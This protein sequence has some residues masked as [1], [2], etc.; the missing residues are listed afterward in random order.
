MQRTMGALLTCIVLATGLLAGG[1]QSKQA[2]RSGALSAAGTIE[3]EE[4]HV[5]PETGG[6]LVELAAEKGSTVEAGTILARLDTALL[7]AQRDHARSAVD[8]AQAA[9]QV[10]QAQL[11]KARAGARP[12]E[13]AAARSALAASEAG[14]KAAQAQRD[15][16]QARQSS[17]EA[18]L[19]AAQGQVKITE[20]SQAAAQAGIDAAQASLTRAKV[21]AT[22]E[23]LGIAEHAVEEAR[24]ALWGAQAQ[25]DSICGGVGRATK[26]S[27]CDGAKAAVQRAEEEVRM[28]ELRL[29]ETRKGARSEDLA[30]LQA[31]VNQA[32][33]GLQGA[34]AQGGTAQ[35]GVEA[36]Q[37]SL[38][39]SAADLAGADAGL[40]VAKAQRDQAQAA[41]DLMQAGARR[42]DLASLEAQ[43]R[44]A[45]A[46]LA[47][48]QAALRGIETQLARMT[49]IA[50]VRGVVLER[51]GHVG[52]L[53]AQGTPIFTLADLT[54]LTLTVYIPEAELGQVALHQ[55]ARVT[56]DAYKQGFTGRVTHIASRAEFT[57]K[58]VEMRE[59]RVNMVFAVEISLDNPEG[60]LL[61]GMPA[62]VAFAAR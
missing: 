38:A 7:D 61:P 49:I 46:A 27:D 39:L 35:A 23:E 12:E 18:N 36:A 24:N 59:E 22:A 26:Q 50:P 25:R 51:A 57:P 33:A 34:Q 58:N 9:L 1:C 19:K 48:A 55:E 52:E 62:D 11:E 44:E 6:R 10:A 20:A 5:A 45:S 14:L 31:G 42:E 8:Q 41:L 21:G 32:H 15:A 47:G 28:A 40:E 29:E 16:A 4:I 13:F 3:A 54:R 37:A 60:N 17:A 30:A 2:S 56:V 53:I 43:V